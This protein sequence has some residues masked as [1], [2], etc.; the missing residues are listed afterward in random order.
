MLTTGG[1]L[2]PPEDRIQH[3]L[4]FPPLKDENTIRIGSFGDS[5]TYGDEVDKTE[6]YPYQLQELFNKNFPNKKIE[7]LNFGKGGAGFQEQ[8][9]LWEKYSNKYKLDYILLGPRGFYSDRDITFSRNWGFTNF[10][11]PKTRFILLNNNNLKRIHIKGDSLQ[12]RY[13][14]YYKLI[15]S[16]TALR[17][18]I[19]PFQIWEK[20]FPFLRHKLYNHFYYYKKNSSNKDESVKINE[21]LLKKIKKLYDKRIL[22][23]TDKRWVF[24]AYQSIEKLYNLNLI[25]LKTNRFYRVFRHKSSLGN[26]IIAKIYFNALI[27]KKT[28][29][30]KTLNCHFNEINSTPKDKAIRSKNF[31]YNN[32]DFIK[33]KLDR[34]L[35]AVQS[36]QITNKNTPI[37]TLR[38]NAS[39]HHYIEGSYSNYKIKETKSFIA[40]FNKFNFLESPFIP[41][42]IPLKRGMKIYI[43]TANKTKIA[44]GEIQ[45]LDTYKKFFVFYSK[46]IYSY[47]VTDG[48]RYKSYFL[49]EIIPSFLK[50]KIKKGSI[51]LFVENYK[52]GKLEFYDLYRL[53][54]I[55]VNGYE[56]SFLIPSGLIPRSLLRTE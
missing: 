11:Y 27:G 28:F 42:S 25:Y 37:A 3:F 5:H 1:R 16:W 50:E 19:N 48:N 15:P 29:S 52:L 46:H 43:Q 55:P 41:V 17:Y 45:P 30:L 40:F 13:K 9:F 34:D 56:K 36:I 35:F 53:T 32:E 6:S 18:D 2:V 33:E 23:F 4:N 24:N 7:V 31:K 51:K 38:Y 47:S 12:K 14:N 20:F 54:F 44:L 39:N 22:F 26:E 10:G 21:I 8:F 49:S